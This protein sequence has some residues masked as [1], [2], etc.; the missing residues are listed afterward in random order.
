MSIVLFTYKRGA[1]ESATAE[2][3][4]A[5]HKK[6]DDIDTQWRLNKTEFDKH[7]RELEHD[8]QNWRDDIEKGLDQRLAGIIGQTNLLRDQLSEVRENIAKNYMT[9]PE[10]SAIESRVTDGQGRIIDRLE[11]FEGRLSDM[12]KSILEAIRKNGS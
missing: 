8:R 9:K 2:S 7:L 10:I 5:A 11:K 6:L 4:K 1:S 12:Q 3:L